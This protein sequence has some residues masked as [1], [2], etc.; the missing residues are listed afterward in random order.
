ML[1][2]TINA[3]T[4]IK[5]KTKIRQA[6]YKKKVNKTHTHTMKLFLRGLN[7]SGFK[8]SSEKTRLCTVNP[9]PKGIAAEKT[10]GVGI[11]PLPQ[12][13]HWITSP[14]RYPSATASDTFLL[15]VDFWIVNHVFLFFFFFFFLKFFSFWLIL[16][17]YDNGVWLYHSMN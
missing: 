14:T 1:F 17:V 2:D 10:S 5:T 8:V 13:K 3:C 9:L 4:C 16:T 12:C 15:L 11:E 6:Y 7:F